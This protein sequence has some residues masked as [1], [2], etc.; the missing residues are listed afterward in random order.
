MQ[1]VQ[2]SLATEVTGYGLDARDSI[3]GKI[4]VLRFAITSRLAVGS[5]RNQ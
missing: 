2:Y 1:G 4:Q 3:P 5:P